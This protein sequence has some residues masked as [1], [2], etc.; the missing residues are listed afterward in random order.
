[1]WLVKGILYYDI[2]SNLELEKF[3]I[4][5]LLPEFSAFLYSSTTPWRLKRITKHDDTRWNLKGKKNYLK[6]CL[7]IHFDI[8]SNSCTEILLEIWNWEMIQITWGLLAE[9]QL[10]CKLEPK[11]QHPEKVRKDFIKSQGT[12]SNYF[13]FQ[14]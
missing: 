7:L 5:L 3:L 8:L 6:H 2:V 10:G 9:C 4:R 13:W 1:M 12:S 11:S 14:S